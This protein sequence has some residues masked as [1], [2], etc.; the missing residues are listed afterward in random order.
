MSEAQSSYVISFDRAANLI[1]TD[2]RNG[3]K[4]VARKMFV[5]KVNFGRIVV[6]LAFASYLHN[7]LHV[8]L[9]KETIELMDELMDN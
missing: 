8:D 7:Q 2:V 3:F 9:E 6:L 5:D 1:S 4:R